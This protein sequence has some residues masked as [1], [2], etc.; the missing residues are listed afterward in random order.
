MR[1][2]GR[3]RS[4]PIGRMRY[5]VIRA[6]V[7]EQYWFPASIRADEEAMVGSATVHVRV[8]VKYSNYK[9]R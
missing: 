2:C 5:Q 8:T 1:L 4:A 3:S 7:A 6:P 9:A